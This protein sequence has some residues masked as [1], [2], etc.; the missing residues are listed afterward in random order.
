MGKQEG[1][2]SQPRQSIFLIAHFG[3]PINLFLSEI[4]W[5]LFGQL[6]PGWQFAWL[7]WLGLTISCNA[8]REIVRLFERVFIED[9]A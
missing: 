8:P 1:D 6:L 9:F 2:L 7:V 3:L 4:A 5:V